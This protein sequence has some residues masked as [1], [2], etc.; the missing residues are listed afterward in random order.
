[1]PRSS[2]RRLVLAALLAV[3][4]GS[5]LTGPDPAVPPK[6]GPF[7]PSVLHEIRVDMAAGDWQTLK[8]LYWKDDFYPATVTIDGETVP[9]VGVRSRGQGSRS[10]TKPSLKVDF[11][12]YVRGQR[13]RGQKS[14][15][16]KNLVQDVSMLRDYLA[17]AVF[18]GMGIAAPR[19]SFTRLSV[20]GEAMGLFNLVESVE[21]PFLHS[22]FGED[23]GNLFNYEYG[24][25]PDAIA[26]DLGDRGPRPEDYIPR[27]FKPETNTDRFDGRGL[28]ELIRTVNDAP[29]SSFVADV[30]RYIDVDK[31]LTYIA[32]ENALAEQDGF[33]GRF[34]MNNFFLY[35]YAATT[36]FVAIPWDKNTA[37]TDSVWP[38]D[39]NLHTNVLTR[40]LTGDPAK[41]EVYREAVARAGRSF[42]NDG[43]LVPRLD[44]AYALIRQAALADTRKPYTNEQFEG[45]VEGLRGLIGARAADIA[46]QT[47]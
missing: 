19:Y 29:P 28:V 3:S 43:Y 37:F 30:S 11:N 14:L 13:H 44:A 47:R 8:D 1:M 5:D 45:G 16:L 23:G 15:A 27:P 7:D 6:S 40:R 34:G 41:L 18:E 26:Y 32:V 42:V 10:E 46:A 12:H 4:C 24:M 36:R 31:F 33:A 25:P 9:R 22:R 2:R 21:E 20:N 38:I 35:Q 39:Y 17:M